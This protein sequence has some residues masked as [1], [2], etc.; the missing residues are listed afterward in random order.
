MG[1]VKLHI[2]DE[3]YKRTEMRVGYS[4]KELTPNFCNYNERKITIFQYASNR[5]ITM[6]DLDGG[7]GTEPNT[8]TVQK[9]DTFWDLSKQSGGAYSVED[10]KKW[11]PG[12]NPDKLQ[13]GQAINIPALNGQTEIYEEE[14]S[15]RPPKIVIVVI[16]EEKYPNIYKNHLRGMLKGNPSTLTY[17]SNRA[18]AV[19]RRYE[20]LKASGLPASSASHRDEYPYATTMEGGANASVMPVPAEENTRHGG[21]ISS[22]I[23][24]NNMRTGDKFQI[25]LIPNNKQKEQ[26]RIPAPSPIPVPAVRAPSPSYVTEN[27]VRSIGIVAAGYAVLK[28][29]DAAL[30]RILCP[31]FI[32][33]VTTP[34]MYEFNPNQTL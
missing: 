29:I 27:T 12:V 6:I 25:M 32:M 9:G 1:C 11:N 14:A 13:I 15:V 10:L 31:I 8:Y 18:N 7:E 5:P 28:F 24:A 2:L 22:L 23:K 4:K 19:R 30:S 20:A 26:Y 17:D 16:K 21:Y 33:P 34:N 3:Q